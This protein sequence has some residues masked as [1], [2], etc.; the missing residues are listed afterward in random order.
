[1]SCVSCMVCRMS[2]SYVCREVSRRSLFSSFPSVQRSWKP[3]EEPAIPLRKTLGQCGALHFVT[4]HYYPS[5]P[6][7]RQHLLLV[8]Q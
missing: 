1:V 7:H 6:C 8:L 2:W 3:V 4:S 5:I